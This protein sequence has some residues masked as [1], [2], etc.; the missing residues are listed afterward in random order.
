LGPSKAI[1]ILLTYFL[2]PCCV[3]F[4]HFPR[5]PCHIQH[6]HN[7]HIF[8]HNTTHF[9]FLPNLPCKIQKLK[10]STK[11]TCECVPYCDAWRHL[12]A[13]V[14]GDCNILLFIGFFLLMTPSSCRNGHSMA[15]CMV[16]QHLLEACTI[17]L[18]VFSYY[19]TLKFSGT[20]VGRYCRYYRL[21]HTVVLASHFRFALVLF[22]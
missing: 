5:L 8:L 3:L 7:R 15:F 4:P 22:I 1:K 21:T 10:L 16:G 12:G 19:V 11:N 17:S 2:A 14:K 9:I 18:T 20:R 13:F 6:T